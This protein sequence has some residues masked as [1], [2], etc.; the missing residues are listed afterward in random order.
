MGVAQLVRE[1]REE[2]LRR[3]VERVEGMHDAKARASPSLICNGL[4]R[5]FDRLLLELDHAAPPEEASLAGSPAMVGAELGEQRQLLGLDIVSMA[6]EWAVLRDIILELLIES[7]TKV[8]LWD[9]QVLSRQISAAMLMSLEGFVSASE[10]ERRRLSAQHTMM[11]AHDVRNQ[12]TAALA[13]VGFLEREPD[14][15]DTAI[16]WLHQSLGAVQHLLER[17]LTV[18]RID[19]IAGG[20]EISR[21]PLVIHDLLR[22]VVH[23]LAPLARS[24]GVTLSIEAIGDLYLLGDRRLLHSAVA[25]LAGNAVK[26]TG[27]GTTV[28]MIASV[29]GDRIEVDI[30][31]RCGGLPPGMI[32]RMFTPHV[33]GSGEASGFG[34]GLAIAK[35]AVEAHG[36]SVTASNQPGEGCCFHLSLPGVG[37]RH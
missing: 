10:R 28:R 14:E 7:D 12:L 5:F 16:A 24:R 17:E 26:F 34:L 22:A 8:E 6:R 36:G 13:A 2:V 1:G 32:D 33:R 11:L 25:N 20:E 31:D 27:P 35:Q 4:P 18:A 30:A 37:G 15:R 3:F 23:E 21:E 29:V 9:Y 19:A